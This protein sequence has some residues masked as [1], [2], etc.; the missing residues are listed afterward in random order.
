MYT[1]YG[2]PSASEYG[3]MMSEANKNISTDGFT[4][5][6]NNAGWLGYYITTP[7]DKKYQLVKNSTFGDTGYHLCEYTPAPFRTGK[8]LDL[9]FKNLEECKQ[10]LLENEIAS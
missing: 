2:E 6:H 1:M 3:R 9:Q 8:P 7:S 5:V 4:C 10:Y